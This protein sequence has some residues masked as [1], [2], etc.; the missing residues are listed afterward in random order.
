MLIVSN[1]LMNFKKHSKKSELFTHYFIGL[2]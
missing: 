2:L 1:L